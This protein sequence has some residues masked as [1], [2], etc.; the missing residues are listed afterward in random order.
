MRY[1]CTCCGYVYDPEK[2]DEMNKIPPG[3]EF[4]DL[5]EGW[6]CPLCYADTDK[7]DPLD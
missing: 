1:I 3:V 5:P 7:F 2:G 6:V 4:G